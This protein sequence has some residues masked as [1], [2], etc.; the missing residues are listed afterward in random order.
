MTPQRLG[1][2]LDAHG[3]ALVLF[4]GQW[5]AT[6]DD[7]VQDAMVKL[8]TRQPTPERIV[9]WLYRVV[10]NG[11][12]NAGR[13]ARRR[14]R[15]EAAAAEAE[16]AWFV[17]AETDAIDAHEAAAAMDT[18]P[19]EQREVIVAHVWGGLSFD[20]IG[21]LIG[22]GTRTAHRRYVTGLSALR[23]KLGVPCPNETDTTT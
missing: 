22:R 16:R 15:H 1:Q 17:P 13:S 6:P 14:H 23:D 4:A 3:A 11:A 19:V 2:L 5:C 20:E 21:N 8:V 7:V 10:R 9:P 12:M 18:L